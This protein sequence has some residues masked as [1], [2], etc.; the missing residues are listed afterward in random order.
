MRE[1][2]FDDQIT[3]RENSNRGQARSSR[4]Q[5]DVLRDPPEFVSGNRSD[6]NLDGVDTDIFDF[7]VGGL[8]RR[9]S[10]YD[11]AELFS[12]YGRII[13]AEPVKTFAFVNVETTADRAMAAIH[14]LS[15]TLQF[16]NKIFVQFRKGSKYEHLNK[17]D[18]NEMRDDYQVEKDKTRRQ[19][20]PSMSDDGIVIVGEVGKGIKSS[21]QEDLTL[22]AQNGPGVKD[23]M[24]LSR[25]R[26]TTIS[27]KPQC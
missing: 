24:Q 17:G 4:H 21:I 3:R 20:R 18:D 1:A 11:L 13:K 26:G 6:D 25:G 22:V 5:S 12:R 8:V 19:T 14:Q 23:Q 7:F 15:G 27:C 2:Y 10:S 9:V 16:D